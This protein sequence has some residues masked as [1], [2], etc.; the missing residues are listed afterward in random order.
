MTKER[1]DKG[2][3]C[4]RSRGL[5]KLDTMSAAEVVG[6]IVLP[7]ADEDSPV[8]QTFRSRAIRVFYKGSVVDRDSSPSR[9]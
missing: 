6:H 5:L 3:G 8:T 1:Y 9:N 7:T 2:V 4:T